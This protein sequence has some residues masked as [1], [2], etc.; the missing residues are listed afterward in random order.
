[1]DDTTLN[2]IITG[3]A[4][5][6]GALIGA[7]SASFVAWVQHKRQTAA[8]RTEKRRKVEHDSARECEE[9]CVRI[10]DNME[11][12]R[13]PAYAE[14]GPEQ[15]ERDNRAHEALTRL[16]SVS[17]YLPDALRQRVE[18][19]GNIALQADELAYG[20]ST[21]VPC[22]YD[23]PY[24]MCWNVKREIRAIVAAFL[25]DER[26]SL[27]EPSHKIREYG[28]ALDDLDKQHEEYYEISSK[29]TSA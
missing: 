15:E 27:P 24:T 1:M 7:G 3:G 17:L 29:R 2:A 4:G 18:T 26:Q 12:V 8:E 13:H 9:L 25:K 23:S 19:L 11:N 14:H 16:N 6:G 22:H 5:L 20:G 10:A 28:V 21:N